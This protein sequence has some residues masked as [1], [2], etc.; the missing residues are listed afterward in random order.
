ME[1]FYK[2]AC[3]S[4]TNMFSIHLNKTTFI[5]KHIYFIIPC[6]I[7]NINSNKFRQKVQGKTVIHLPVITYKTLRN[8]KFSVMCF[9][10]PSSSS[11]L[12]YYKTLRDHACQ[13]DQV[14]VKK[15]NSDMGGGGGRKQHFFKAAQQFCK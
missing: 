3:V 13:L 4:L 14:L 2:D 6:R 15:K 10:F 12:Q 11:V 7:H 8:P 1:S 5:Q 9:C